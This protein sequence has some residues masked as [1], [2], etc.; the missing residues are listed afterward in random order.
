[1]QRTILFGILLAA[2]FSLTALSAPLSAQSTSP[3]ASHT[4]RNTSKVSLK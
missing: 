4:D 2:L 1:M 3:D